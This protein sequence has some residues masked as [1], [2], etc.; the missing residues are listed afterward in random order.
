MFLRPWGRKGPRCGVKVPREGLVLST[1]QGVL[2]WK[3]SQ[4]QQ[5][6][7]FRHRG[8]PGNRQEGLQHCAGP[9]AAVVYEESP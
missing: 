5:V 1:A 2:C 7:R 3:P 9:V 8:P 4:S 6:G